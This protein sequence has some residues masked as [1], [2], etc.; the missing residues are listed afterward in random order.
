MI[1]KL[2]NTKKYCYLY[3]HG[4]FTTA[5]VI[6]INQSYWEHNGRTMSRY[7]FEYFI[8][9][10]KYNY[11]FK[12]AYHREITLGTKMELYFDHRF[13]EKPFIPE[14]FRVKVLKENSEK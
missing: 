11:I 4:K 5:V 6:D 7:N 9:G 1:F 12:S 13:S 3:I 2:I 8:N 10:R 14:L